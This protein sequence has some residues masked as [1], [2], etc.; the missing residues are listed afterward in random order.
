M[1]GAT[2]TPTS[3]GQDCQKELVFRGA[4]VLGGPIGNLT[5]FQVKLSKFMQGMIGGGCLQ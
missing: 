2:D 3:I 5:S 4:T 1:K